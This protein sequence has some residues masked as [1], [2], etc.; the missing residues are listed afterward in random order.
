MFQPHFTALALLWARL[1]DEMMLL[2]VQEDVVV[3]LQPFL[4]AQAHCFPP[5]QLDLLLQGSVVRSDEQRF[6]ELAGES[7][8]SETHR[9]FL[10]NV[11]MVLYLRQSGPLLMDAVPPQRSVSVSR[12]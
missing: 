4:R 11:M 7:D 6:A 10:V 3:G 2:R 5:A 9:V 8:T 12:I 1:Q